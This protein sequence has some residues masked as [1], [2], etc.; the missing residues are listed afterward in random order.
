M[1][2]LV[3]RYQ[4]RVFALCYRMLGQ[5]QDAEDAAQETFIRALRSL[6]RFD[7]SRDL[8]PWLLAI[9]GNRCRTALSVRKRRPAHQPL[10]EPH[11]DATPEQ[12]PARCLAEEVKLALAALRHEYRQAF[13]LFHEHQMSYAEIGESLDRPLGTIKTWVHRARK[14]MIEFLHRRGVTQQPVR[15]VDAAVGERGDE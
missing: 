14:E 12:E 3:E 6:H 9:A 7:L 13:V 10:V 4:G 15:A 1:L 5:R 8:E 11:P 2:A